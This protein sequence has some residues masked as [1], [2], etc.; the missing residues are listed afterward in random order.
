MAKGSDLLWFA[1]L[2]ACAAPPLAPDAPRAE[3]GATP[4]APSEQT[5][6]PSVPS[7]GSAT[8]PPHAAVAASTSPAASAAAAPVVLVRNT[9]LVAQFV[10]IDD[11]PRGRVDSGAEQAFPVEPGAHALSFTDSSRRGTNP[12]FAAE[13]FDPGFVYRYEIVAR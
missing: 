4:A 10:W 11:Q 8:V 5:T 1:L 12:A 9:L 7:A 3:P 6:A 2:G 13:V